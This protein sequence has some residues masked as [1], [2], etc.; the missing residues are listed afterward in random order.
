[1]RSASSACLH[2]SFVP[3]AFSGRVERYAD[4]SLPSE[5]WNWD[6]IRADFQRVFLR[7]PLFADDETIGLRPQDLYE[8]LGDK[9]QALYAAKEADV[10]EELMRELE[11]LATLRVI[12]D[13]WR[14]HLYAMDQ[15]KEGIGLRAYGQKDPLLEYKSEAFSMFTD[16]LSQIS[17]EVV[18]LIFKA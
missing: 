4:E 8:L 10:S 5:E 16:M 7:P 12:D 9:A 15:M 2:C 3:L 18:A 17:E 14:D 6:G 11:R 13:R 1:M